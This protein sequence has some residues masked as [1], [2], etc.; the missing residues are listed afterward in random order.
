MRQTFMCDDV[1]TSQGL[2]RAFRR[3]HVYEDVIETYQ[4]NILREFPFRV[5]YDKERAI[6]TGGVCSL[7]SGKK[8]M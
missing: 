8:A 2:T 3:D 4:E 1:E 6:D 7:P 5:R